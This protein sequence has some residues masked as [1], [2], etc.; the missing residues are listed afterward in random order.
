VSVHAR[1]LALAPT[2]L[3]GA[4]PDLSSIP[5]LD[6]LHLENNKLSSVGGEAFCKFL[7][8]ECVLSGVAFDCAAE[9]LPECAIAKCSATCS[10]SEL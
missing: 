4:V 1:T 6:M 5:G 9:P 8:R 3:V 10:K 7:P 2:Q